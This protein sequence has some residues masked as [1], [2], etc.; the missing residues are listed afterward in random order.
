MHITNLQVTHAVI[1]EQQLNDYLIRIYLNLSLSLNFSCTELEITVL[2]EEFE[3]DGVIVTLEWTEINFAYSYNVSLYP[4]LEITSIG[5][6]S[7]QLKV[8]YNDLHNVS[9][10]AI[11]PC[12]HQKD[13][14]TSLDCLSLYY[15]EY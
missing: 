3:E 10:V 12:R 6:A 11:L 15:S 13:T 14:A 7:V 4:K 5:K 1:N 8:P 9:I 2:S